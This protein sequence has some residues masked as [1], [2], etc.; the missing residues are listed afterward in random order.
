MQQFHDDRMEEVKILAEFDLEREK[1]FLSLSV[2]DFYFHI[3][4]KQNH[5]KDG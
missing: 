3:L 2:D 4:I 1:Q 5:Q